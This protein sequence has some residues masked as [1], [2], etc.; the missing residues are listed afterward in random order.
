MKCFQIYDWKV[1]LDKSRGSLKWQMIDHDKGF[2]LQ[3]GPTDGNQWKFFFW[4]LCKFLF[5]DRGGLLTAWGF[6][7]D[8]KAATANL[9]KTEI[10]NTDLSNAPRGFRFVPPP[11]HQLRQN[12][13]QFLLM[14]VSSCQ[15]TLDF[16][17]VVWVL[18]SWWV[19]SLLSSDW[20][21]NCSRGSAIST[22]G[23]EVYKCT[24]QLWR[25]LTS[26]CST[27]LNLL[28]V[29]NESSGTADMENLASSISRPVQREFCCTK[30]MNFPS[31]LHLKVSY[32]TYGK[33]VGITAVAKDG[34]SRGRCTQQCC[35]MNRLV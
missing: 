32:K 7:Q 29:G 8:S 25:V 4:L 3:G 13:S 16:T 33:T 1:Q 34:F 30:P 15:I 31:I 21:Q 10:L 28:C 27:C 12:H 18:K 23:F 22:S 11:P 9:I 2:P 17:E 19:W 20:F 6:N 24:Y 35:A 14:Q 26:E 5:Q